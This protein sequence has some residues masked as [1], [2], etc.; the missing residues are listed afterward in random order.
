MGLRPRIARPCTIQGYAYVI[1]IELIFSCMPF[2]SASQPPSHSS[3]LFCR[4]VLVDYFAAMRLE[5]RFLAYECAHRAHQDT[6]SIERIGIRWTTLH[7][8]WT[9]RRISSYYSRSIKMRPRERLQDHMLFMICASGSMYNFSFHW[10]D[11]GQ[12]TA[13]LIGPPP[14]PPAPDVEEY[15]SIDLEKMSNV[16]RE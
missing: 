3:L 4:Y 12:F 13:N 6:S 5:C 8:Q 7:H 9:I 11:R 2:S 1:V 16:L 10:S 15:D 14:S